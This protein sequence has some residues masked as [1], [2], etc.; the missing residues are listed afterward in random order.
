MVTP[1]RFRSNAAVQ[2][3]ALEA[4]EELI[5]RDL[6]EISIWIVNPGVQMSC[7]PREV[8]VTG[9]EQLSSRELLNARLGLP[10]SDF[11]GPGIT[12]RLR[13]GYRLGTEQEEG[14]AYEQMEKA[15]EPSSVGQTVR[16]YQEAPKRRGEW[17][18][19]I[20]EASTIGVAACTALT[21]ARLSY[22]IISQLFSTDTVIFPSLLVGITTFVAVYMLA[23]PDS[24][25]RYVK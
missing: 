18:P 3:K 4:I 19:I 17:R 21:I 10:A 13:G 12:I 6:L 5:T 24:F 14:R 16:L 2:A 25:V 15:L 9:G 1:I 22:W 8:F 11:S 23:M 20:K 7:R